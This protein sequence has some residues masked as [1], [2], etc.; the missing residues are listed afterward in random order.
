MAV[1]PEADIEAKYIKLADRS[2]CIGPASST[3]GY[4]QRAGHH[5]GGQVTDSR[6]STATASSREHRLRRARRAVGF[7]FIGPR[8]PSHHPP[9]GRQGISQD[10]MRQPALP[11]V[12]GRA[13]RRT[14]PEPKEIDQDPGGAVGYPV[15][16]RE[17]AGGIAR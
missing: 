5:F 14:L 1:P 2:V 12:R 11:C 4:L 17:A 6:P 3:L 15:I 7:V 13:P 9:D 16:I 8:S 10:A